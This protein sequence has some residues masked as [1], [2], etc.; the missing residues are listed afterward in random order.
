MVVSSNELLVGMVV[1]L[2]FVEFVCWFVFGCRLR[3]VVFG[4]MLLISGYLRVGLCFT[5]WW[6]WSAYPVF[7]AYY[8]CCLELVDVSYGCSDWFACVRVLSWCCLLCGDLV[9]L[10]FPGLGLVFRQGWLIVLWRLWPVRF[11]FAW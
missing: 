5:G 6:L 2:S 3:E 11:G 8:L 10:V 7:V 4:W 9:V 1:S